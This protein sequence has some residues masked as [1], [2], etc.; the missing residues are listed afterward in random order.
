MSTFDV[1]QIFTFASQ[2]E[3]N[4]Y[5]FYTAMADRQENEVVKKLFSFLA[6]EEV[7]HQKT[8]EGILAG[9]EDRS[10]VES[11]PTEYFDYLRAFIDKTIFPKDAT[12]DD[13]DR[14]ED[15]SAVLEYSIG[16]E[17]D[18]ILYYHEVKSF[19]PESEH[20]IIDKII[21]EEHRHYVK[22]SE[23]AKQIA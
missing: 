18:S 13:P 23:L 15:L 6:D 9:L 10:P 7:K 19:A 11:P 8:F 17:S 22:L 21:Q 1:R 16:R 4:G 20:K 12:E 14:F 5:K 3:E 2:I